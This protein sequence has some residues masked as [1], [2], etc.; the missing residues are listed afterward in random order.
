MHEGRRNKNASAEVT[1]EEEKVMRDGKAGKAAHYDRK[2]A[3][4]DSVRQWQVL[5]ESGEVLTYLQYSK[6]ESE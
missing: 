1:R 5:W 2:R 4:C 3:R 6:P